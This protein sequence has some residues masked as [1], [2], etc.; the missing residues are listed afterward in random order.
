MEGWM[1]DSSGAVITEKKLADS[2]FFSSP[3][4]PKP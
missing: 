3:S 2:L 1:P 4:F